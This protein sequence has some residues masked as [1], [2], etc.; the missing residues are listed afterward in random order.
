MKMVARFW[1]QS[2]LLFSVFLLYNVVRESV[3]MDLEAFV[4]RRESYTGP[5]PCTGPLWSDSSPVGA[6]TTILRLTHLSIT[7]KRGHGG[8]AP[9]VGRLLWVLLLVCGDVELNPGPRY[10][11]TVCS[12]GVGNT[13]QAIKCD[14]CGQWCH[15]ACGGMTEEEYDSYHWMDL[16][17]CALDA[18]STSCHWTQM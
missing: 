11:C 6:V 8:R 15:A 9:M 4:S 14:G 7:A 3:A 1:L 17:G 2:L 13:Q 16:T 12:L 18:C 5:T 10:P